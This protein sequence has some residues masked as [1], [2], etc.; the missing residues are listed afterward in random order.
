MIH[1]EYFDMDEDALPIGA[2][3]MS[4]VVLDYLFRAVGKK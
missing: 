3:A 4:N 2:R 1:T